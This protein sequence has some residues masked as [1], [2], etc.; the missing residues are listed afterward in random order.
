MRPW[1]G[2]TLTTAVSVD[3]TVT[4]TGAAG[5]CGVPDESSVAMLKGS[6]EP[7]A[8]NGEKYGSTQYWTNRSCGVDTRTRSVSGRMAGADAMTRVE[9]CRPARMTN[10]PVR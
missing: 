4:A 8:I 9:P 10:E 3:V 6:S 5:V 7:S 2:G 1:P